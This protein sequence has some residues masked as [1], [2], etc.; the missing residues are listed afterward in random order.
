MWCL[1]LSKQKKIR[2]EEGKTERKR[3]G[4]SGLSELQAG[5]ENRYSKQ[6][7]S[8]GGCPEGF[9][10]KQTTH[11]PQYLENTPSLLIPSDKQASTASIIS[12]IPFIYFGDHSP[13]PVL[14]LSLTTGFVGPFIYSSPRLWKKQPC[15]TSPRLRKT[16]LHVC[17]DLPQNPNI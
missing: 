15:A 12:L 5:E 13:S 3:A 2:E 11:K 7:S 6:Q 17:K 8:T 16:L 14:C 9:V 10:S 1:F 4:S